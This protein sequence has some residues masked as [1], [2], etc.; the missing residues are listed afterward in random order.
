M[1]LAL[2]MEILPNFGLGEIID[3]SPPQ[4]PIAMVENDP[5]QESE[6]MHKDAGFVANTEAIFKAHEGMTVTATSQ[7]KDKGKVIYQER[8]GE[9]A[10]LLSDQAIKLLECCNLLAFSKRIRSY[11]YRHE[12]RNRARNF[13]V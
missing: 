3:V 5:A 12:Q 10:V 8:L 4:S 11:L 13:G 7:I 2:P 6:L 9:E 1:G